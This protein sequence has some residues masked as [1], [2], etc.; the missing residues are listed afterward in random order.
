MTFWELL[1]T[2]NSKPI[3]N[4]DKNYSEDFKDFISKW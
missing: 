2:I 4:L 1:E 3:P